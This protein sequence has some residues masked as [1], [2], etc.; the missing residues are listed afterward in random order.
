[1]LVPVPA[2][3][4]RRRREGFN[5]AAE[6]ARAV[7]RAAELPVLDVLR[8]DR[9]SRPQVGLERRARLANAPHSVSIRGGFCGRRP[10]IAPVVVLVDDVY[11][12]GATLDACARA[13]RGA[14]AREAVAVTFARAVLS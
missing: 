8:R 1:V 7:G 6:L 11:T 3:P 12:T 13:L 10:A 2:H 4:A 14:G 5:Q 9:A